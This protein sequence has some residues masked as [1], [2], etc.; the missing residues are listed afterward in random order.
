[1]RTP[2]TSSRISRSSSTTRMSRAIGRTPCHASFGGLAPL[3]RRFAREPQGHASAAPFGGCENHL[4]P[5]FLD[6]LVD[7]REAK[8]R[9]LLAR[10]DV[11]LHDTIAILRQTDAVV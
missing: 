9:A 7:D 8:A 6:D 2:E 4:P 5:M 11:G 10:R 1:H 3:R